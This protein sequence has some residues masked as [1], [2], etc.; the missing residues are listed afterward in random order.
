MDLSG[1]RVQAVVRFNPLERD[2][3]TGSGNGFSE[4]AAVPQASAE[5]LALLVDRLV[6]EREFPESE[7]TK[8]L[9]LRS[10]LLSEF[11]DRDEWLRVEPVGTEPRLLPAAAEKQIRPP[12]KRLGVNFL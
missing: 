3:G 6:P 2:V 9:D 10:A 5:P 11:H 12:A 7:R 4:I 8:L 1:Y